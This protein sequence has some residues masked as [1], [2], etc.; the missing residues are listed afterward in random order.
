MNLR[1]GSMAARQ[2]T[3]GAGDAP[4]YWNDA[5]PAARAGADPW[6]Q[7]PSI[8]L[9]DHDP[10]LRRSVETYLQEH[11]M[12]VL[13][14]C[15]ARDVA[16]R[17]AGGEPSLVLLD[18]RLDQSGG[19]GL[20]QEIRAH[21]DIPVIVT[22][23]E[24]GDEIDRVLGLELGADDYV[25]EPYCLR[26]LVARI[27]AVLRRREPGGRCAAS[28]KGERVRFQFGGWQLSRRTRRLTDAAGNPVRLTKGEYALL[29][30][31]L[32]AP[33]RP[34]SREQLLQATRVHEDVFDRSIDVQ[35]YRLRRRLEDD[36]RAPRVIKTERGFGYVFAL[37]VE[38]F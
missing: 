18:L 29:N 19:F 38:S 13:S 11:N 3:A 9:V 36:P 4:L 23:G 1:I 14:A 30:A 8:L 21:S 20:L 31:F 7:R 16:G 25:A 26:E 24:R 10:A 5:A 27:R 33:L 28:L 37:A 6:S 22:N 35:I 15:D 12:R 32:E 34:L 2:S 17:V